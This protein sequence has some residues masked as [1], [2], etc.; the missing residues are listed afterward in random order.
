[1]FLFQTESRCSSKM[2]LHHQTAAEEHS[3]SKLRVHLHELISPDYDTIKDTLEPATGQ[4]WADLA[5]LAE[6]TTNL[7]SDDLSDGLNSAK[8]QMG[9]ASE[10]IKAC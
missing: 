7:S 8:D 9:A 3:E 4:P 1:M 6:D 5:S 10:R 2:A